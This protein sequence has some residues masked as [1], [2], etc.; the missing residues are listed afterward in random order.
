[1]ANSFDNDFT[2]TNIDDL[3]F[4]YKKGAAFYHLKCL[5]FG[6]N[7]RNT[8]C[9]I[10]DDRS[11]ATG[12]A[13]YEHLSFGNATADQAHS[14]AFWVKIRDPDSHNWLISK[15]SEDITISLRSVQGKN[16]WPFVW[17][18]TTGMRPHNHLVF[19]S[20]PNPC[21]MWNK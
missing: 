10:K 14:F 5:E 11:L 20:L 1:M 8:Q 17:K 19:R 7:G 4:Q 16:F 21:E 2:I 12:G 9:V 3:T 15:K 13:G 6:V 18:G